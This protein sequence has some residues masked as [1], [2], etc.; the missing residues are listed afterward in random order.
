VWVDVVSGG[1]AIEIFARVD[2]RGWHAE[3]SPV[4][5]HDFVVS[6]IKGA[7]EVSAHYV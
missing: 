5:E 2:E 1:D 3:F 4:F 6:P 7:F